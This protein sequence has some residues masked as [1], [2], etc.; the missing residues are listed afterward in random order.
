MLGFKVPLKNAEEAKRC[1]IE[2]RLLDR[3]GKPVKKGN[4]IIFSVLRR[5][6]ELKKKL[7]GTFLVLDFTKAREAKGYKEH[8][9]GILP[10]KEI[11]E[12]P[13][14]Y[15]VIG[16]VIIVDLKGNRHEKDV[17]EA[18]LKANKSIKTILKKT[19]THEGEFR[20]QP[21]E[22]VSGENKKEAM[23]RENNARMKLDVEKVYFSPRLATERKRIY[24]QV[25]KGEEIL[26]MFSGCAPYPLVL[27]K[28][29][30][31]K[32]ITAIEKNPIAHKYALENV[33]LNKIKNV[34]LIKGDV[35]EEVPKLNKR[36]DRVIMP[37]PKGAEDFLELAFSVSKKGATINFYD[38]EYESELDNGEK[39]ILN[40]AKKSG[41]K[42]KILR[43]VKCGQYPPGKFRICVDFSVI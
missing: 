43:I 12:L 11:E 9:K 39:K 28:N 16:D 2:K 18:I 19:G 26:V 14:A 36:F 35:K 30:K 1:L 4:E 5:D 17:G 41:T 33:K 34:T 7:N 37:L 10:D 32:S 31:A 38:F 24:L 22:Y 27:S 40:A 20:T 13:V 25:K 23:Y 21:L 6:K 42:V 8:L 29:T 15:D 3:A